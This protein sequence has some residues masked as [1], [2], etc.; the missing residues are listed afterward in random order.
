MPLPL[1]A[2]EMGFSI[3]NGLIKLGGRL[4]RAFAENAAQRRGVMMPQKVEIVAPS[5][6]DMIDVLE[7]VVTEYDQRVAAG[8]AE[9]DGFTTDDRKLIVDTISVPDGPRKQVGSSKLIPLM[10]IYAA[11]QLAFETDDPDALTKYAVSV[12]DSGITDEKEVARLVYYLGPGA[13]N[14][15]QGLGWQVGMAIVV[16]LAEVAVA[17]QEQLIKDARVR[18]VAGAVLS[19]LADDGMLET[20]S[21][22][23]F[24]GKLLGATLNGALDA[25]ADLDQD[26]PYLEA[27][28]NALHDARESVPDDKKDEYLLGLVRGR[29]YKRLVSELLEEG[30]VHLGAEDREPFQKIVADLLVEAK[31]LVDTGKLTRSTFDEHW[32]DLVRAALRSVKRNGSALLAAQNELVRDALLAAI[33]SMA[34]STDPKIF[35][36][37]AFF[38]AVES[39][40]AAVAA[41][42]ELLGEG[43]RGEWLQAFY[44]PFAEVVADAGIR[45]AFSPDKVESMVRGVAEQIAA[46][47]DLIAGNAKLPQTMAAEILKAVAAAETLGLGDLAQAAVDGALEVVA[48]NPAL[49]HTDDDG[50][51]SP[52][53]KIAADLAGSLAKK[54]KDGKITRGEAEALAKDGL[55]SLGKHGTA[56]LKEERPLVQVAFEATVDALSQ[57]ESFRGLSETAV[58]MAES[59]IVAL[60]ERNDLTSDTDRQAYAKAILEP[61]ANVVR[62]KGIRATFSDEGLQQ[63]LAGVAGHLAER[64]ELV[65]GSG[66]F[67]QTVVEAMLR[68]IAATGALRVEAL[69]EAGVTGVLEAV[70]ENPG[71]LVKKATDQPNPFA[72]V[73]AGIAKGL[74]ERIKTAGLARTDA[75]TILQVAIEAVRANPSLPEHLRSDLAERIVG[76][77][78]DAAQGNR[79]TL[80]RG[81][82]VV[83]VVHAALRAATQNAEII[84]VDNDGE[85]I[86]SATIAEFLFGIVDEGLRRAGSDLGRGLDLDS[87]PL[88]IGLMIDRWARGDVPV[89]SKDDEKFKKL[90]AQ[91]ADEVRQRAIEG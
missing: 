77:V 44:L 70:S 60:A 42:P 11:D 59:A 73:V 85:P 12:L 66:T 37:D 39:A 58:S 15:A 13:D 40:I 9:P 50:T 49:L 80:L 20:A 61:F 53:A 34:E 54:V 65:V 87:V 43:D 8:D 64:P 76:R 18:R 68:E 51:P 22:R 36:E 4:D 24:A 17:S 88:I 1:A 67:P 33:S 31:R 16:G 57:G 55:R 46:K 72:V 63:L 69:A 91:L 7:A 79:A 84:S 81:S 75:A 48:E 45:K 23:D 6:A 21:G 38:G 35:S 82:A 25:R 30:A 89:I 78:L 14:R 47:P 32:P 41:K 74:A 10:E 27:V 19:R 52:Y 29:G 28:L 90:W 83:W 5:P 56:L 26:N 2:I 62:N 3:A 86:D 71:L